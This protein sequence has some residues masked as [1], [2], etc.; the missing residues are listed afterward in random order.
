MLDN[1]HLCNPSHQP[2]MFDTPQRSKYDCEKR[3]FRPFQPISLVCLKGRLS[4]CSVK[5][6]ALDKFSEDC[7][8][9]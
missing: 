2:I 4:V 9:K 6:L 3:L 1:R 7:Q 8:V 5:A